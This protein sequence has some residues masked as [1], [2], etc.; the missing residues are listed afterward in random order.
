MAADYDVVVVGAG[1]VGGTL[2][3]LLGR[4]GF[5]VA[6][7]EAHEPPAFDISQDID[8]RVSFLPTPYG[9]SVVLRLLNAQA[10]MI[11][12]NLA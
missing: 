11:L 5:E 9:E 10:F 1:M 3:A 2:A 4:A 7:V 6:L 12:S 8:L